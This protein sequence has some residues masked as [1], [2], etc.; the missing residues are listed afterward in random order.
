M[1]VMFA[2]GFGTLRA[3]LRLFLPG[4][5]RLFVPVRLACRAYSGHALRVR[6]KRSPARLSCA[7]F[8]LLRVGAGLAAEPVWQSP[9]NLYAVAYR[10]VLAQKQHYLEVWHEP[11]SLRAPLPTLPLWIDY[12]LYVPLR[13]EESYSAACKA[14]RIP[15]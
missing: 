13:L 1:T 12:D 3:A 14:L 4:A 8:T 9:T 7:A 10:G 15:A 5:R 2:S 11:L 6:R